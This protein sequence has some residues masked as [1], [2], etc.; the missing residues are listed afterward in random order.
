MRY[1]QH[2]AN[3]WPIY[4]QNGPNVSVRYDLG[5]V[6]ARVKGGATVIKTSTFQIFP[7]FGRGGGS[8]N[9]NFFPNSKQSTLSQ[10]GQENYGLFPNFG[11]F[12]IMRAPLSLCQR[13]GQIVAVVLEHFAPFIHRLMEYSAAAQ[14]SEITNQYTLLFQYISKYRYQV[15]FIFFSTTAL[16]LGDT[17]NKQNQVLVLPP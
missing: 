10:G 6:L 1:M 2:L 9:L 3:I 12:L 14:R 7:N 5:T 15:L 16:N 8:S 11:T 17:A 13:L 4:E